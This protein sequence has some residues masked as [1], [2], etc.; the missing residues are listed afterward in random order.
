M[1]SSARKPRSRRKERT[2]SSFETTGK[3][4]GHGKKLLTTQML[5]LTF[6][7]DN[8]GGIFS[9][10]AKHIGDLLIAGQGDACAAGIG[11]PE[12]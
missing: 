6:M 8:I 5:A 9:D 4:F 1:L 7:P 2:A 12:K 3:G 10:L 11:S